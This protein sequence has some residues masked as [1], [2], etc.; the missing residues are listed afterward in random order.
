MLGITTDNYVESW[1]FT[2]KVAYPGEFRKRHSEEFA[3]VF[4]QKFL[5]NLRRKVFRVLLGIERR[6]K[7][8][9]EK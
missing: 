7:S 1:H 3:H 9:I 5:S 2:L 8:K 6:T 4:L